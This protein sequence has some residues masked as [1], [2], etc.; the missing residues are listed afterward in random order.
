MGEKIGEAIKLR[1]DGRLMMGFQ[2]REQD[3]LGCLAAGLCGTVRGT[4]V[5]GGGANLSAGETRRQC[6]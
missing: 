1:F 2:K 5:N 6:L 3:H 4:V